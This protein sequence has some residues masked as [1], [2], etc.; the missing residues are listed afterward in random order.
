LRHA[1]RIDWRTISN[2]TRWLD[3]RLRGMRAMHYRRFGNAEIDVSQIGVGCARIGGTLQSSSRQDQLRLLHAAF[4]AGLTFYDTADMYAQ[5]GSE[6]LLGDAFAARRDRVVIAS[7]V[8]YRFAAPGGFTS[9]VKPLLG[10]VARRLGVR[11]TRVPR[12]MLSTVSEQEFSPAYITSMLEGSLTRLKSDY[13]DIY[14]LHSPPLEVLERGDFAETL[15][16]LKQQG[17]IRYWGVACEHPE[18]VPVALRYAGLS[19]I[20]VSLSLLHQEALASVIPQ[21]A[22]QGVGVIARQVFASGSLARSADQAEA[23]L[24]FVLAQPGVSVALLGMHRPD[25]LN[26]ALGYLAHLE[27]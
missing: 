6:R 21:A 5:G 27:N 11:R 13:I 8:G 25:H 1:P 17:K 22:Q 19:A 12:R 9:R 7:K 20:Q 15:E 26:D 14:Q 24:S 4:D 2:V 3:Q 16:Q 10:G 23:A 18:D